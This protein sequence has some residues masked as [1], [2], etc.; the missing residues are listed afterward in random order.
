[1]MFAAEYASNEVVQT[2]ISAGANVN[3]LNKKGE[4]ALMR[5]AENGELEIVKLLLGAGAKA[6]L[7]NKE[8][9]TALSMTSSEEVKQILISYGATE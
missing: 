2:L 9:E 5:A 3:A 1:L 4:T 6:Q 8:G 7:R